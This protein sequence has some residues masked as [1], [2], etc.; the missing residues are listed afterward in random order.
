MAS[1]RKKFSMWRL[2]TQEDHGN[3]SSMEADQRSLDSGY[4]SI[5]Q[6]TSQHS[7]RVSSQAP[8]ELSS[9]ITSTQKLR[10]TLSTT[11]EVL[12]ATSRGVVEHFHQEPKKADYHDDVAGASNFKSPS[13]SSKE[14]ARCHDTN[15]NSFIS[16]IKGRKR[17]SGFGFSHLLPSEDAS[18]EPPSTPTKDSSFRNV[19][20]KRSS[21]THHSVRKFITSSMRSRKRSSTLGSMDVQRPEDETPES[22]LT[23][24]R[25]SSE[26]APR[27]SVE[28]PITPHSDDCEN[29]FSDCGAMGMTMGTRPTTK[30][31]GLL[32]PS[33]SPT[34]FPSIK[35]EKDSLQE[36]FF[37]CPR[38]EL[39]AHTAP[40]KKGYI[41]DTESDTENKDDGELSL[42]R[43]AAITPALTAVVPQSP[44]ND[45][46]LSPR[47]NLGG[48]P[49]VASPWIKTLPLRPKSGL[50]PLR[51]NN[52]NDHSCSAINDGALDVSQSS[53]ETV[54]SM[55]SRSSFDH[56]RADRSRRYLFTIGNE[57]VSDGIPVE[58]HRPS[59]SPCTIPIHDT[60]EINGTPQRQGTR[61]LISRLTTE[62]LMEAIDRTSGL[63]WMREEDAFQSSASSETLRDEDN[64]EGT[65]KDCGSDYSRHSS[66]ISSID[67][68]L[69]VTQPQDPPIADAEGQVHSISPV[70]AGLAIGSPRSC[71]TPGFKESK[72]KVRRPLSSTSGNQEN[73][74]SLTNVERKSGDGK[75]TVKAEQSYYV[76]AT[77]P[78]NVVTPPQFAMEAFQ[79]PH[80][81]LSAYMGHELEPLSCGTRKSAERTAQPPPGSRSNGP[82]G[83]TSVI[84][85][86]GSVKTTIQSP[87]ASQQGSPLS[88]KAFRAASKAKKRASKQQLKKQNSMS[89]D[90]NLKIEDDED[91]FNFEDDDDEDVSGVLNGE[92]PRWCVPGV[93]SN[94][95]L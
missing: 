29:V 80:T 78:P 61:S 14:P 5:S 9:P 74:G 6:Q 31:A 54:P 10:K 30:S 76:R 59:S 13:P 36:R 82:I 20:P 17:Q 63:E 64:N 39:D 49:S 67:L 56:A 40:E 51:T 50:S 16:S 84:T 93:P 92:R 81:P 83:R 22:S 8:D 3:D 79:S 26:R 25:L 65:G 69:Y 68:D 46:R 2:S 72:N 66:A 90:H 32:F 18:P 87:N 94:I 44:C 23:P 1:L 75:I 35:I 95:R 43:I 88:R 12:A 38:P 48:E 91:I 62:L 77:S 45:P 52:F 4:A 27:I 85:S 70:R 60:V 57:C 47:V 34:N 58:T 55:G 33:A 86:G 21:D 19:T 24:Y 42:K 71:Q 15:Q 7:A 89:V 41:A 28:I 53:P 11:F 37:D 73:F